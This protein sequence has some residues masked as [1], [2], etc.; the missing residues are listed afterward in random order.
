MSNLSDTLNI[1][2]EHR[3]PFADI[4]LPMAIQHTGL[5]HSLLSLSGSSMLSRQKQPSPE[6]VLRQSHHFDKAIVVLRKDIEM[7]KT[8]PCAALNT[9]YTI[10]QTILHC[11]ETISADGSGGDYRCHLQAAHRLINRCQSTNNDLRH[12]A[13]QFLAY[14]TLANSISALRPVHDLRAFAA[15]D[16]PQMSPQVTATSSTTDLLGVL[17]GLI[18]PIFRIRNLRDEI[19]SLRTASQH[20]WCADERL[21]YDAFAID[22]SLRSWTCKFEPNTPAYDASLL[23]RQIAWIY[24]YRTMKPSSPSSELAQGVNEGL[25]YLKRLLPSSTE[26]GLRTWTNGILLPPLY[27]LGCSAFEP[28]Q[29]RGITAGFDAL[30]AY[31]HMGN[32]MHARRVVERIWQM[33]DQGRR[34]DETWD[35]ESVMTG[36]GLDVLVS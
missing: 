32:A 9:D 29:R 24:L 18:S 14:Q 31:S 25:V 15:I 11:I 13:R 30:Q 1:Y 10:L 34:Q 16:S 4:V 2:D 22:A 33:M 7:H 12:F 27:L 23:Y 20:G 8:K 19:R 21:F 35:W 6:L 28:E 17:G 36:M 3:N 5:M 26:P